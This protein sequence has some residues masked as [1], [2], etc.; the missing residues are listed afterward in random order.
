MDFQPRKL[1]PEISHCLM[2]FFFLKKKGTDGIDSPFKNNN[3]QG[4]DV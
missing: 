1:T 3:K 2:L 4:H